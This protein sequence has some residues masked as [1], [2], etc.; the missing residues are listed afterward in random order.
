MSQIERLQFID[1]RIRERG[2]VSLGEVVDRYEITERQARRD[3]DYLRDRLGAPIEWKPASRRYEYE[4]RWDGFA[5][6]DEKALL[7][8]V[9]ARAS[10]G[11]IAYVPLS[12]EDALEK[13]LELVPPGLRKAESAIRYELP[14]YEIADIE[15]LGLIVRALS[16]SRCLDIGYRDAGGRVSARR[17][18]ALRLVNYAGSWYCV[19]FDQSKDELRTFRLSRLSKIA[20]SKDKARAR[21]DQAEIERFLSSS[22]GMFKGS[23]NKRACMRFYGRALAIVRG[24]L[25][26]PEQKR[27]EGSD[28]LRGPFVELSVPVSRWD[29][30]IGRVLRFGAD[31]EAVSPQEF[32]ELWMAEIRRMSA[33]IAED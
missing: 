8:Y 27:S 32:H 11:A 24:E 13:L 10:A 25:W 33:S 14:A 29:E 3:L 1:A 17:I 28:P 22:Y 23:G 4:S 21:I 18:E 7:F 31:A 9:F 20:I 12:D 30:I 16:E 5:F 15:R 19:A 6:A 26:H 2:G